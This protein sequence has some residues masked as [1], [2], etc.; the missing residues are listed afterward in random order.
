MGNEESLC[1]TRRDCKCGKTG[2]P[3]YR[4]K[5]FDGHWAESL[6]KCFLPCRLDELM[7]WREYARI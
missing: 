6:R 2:V 3:K 4:R 1:H 7:R 5:M